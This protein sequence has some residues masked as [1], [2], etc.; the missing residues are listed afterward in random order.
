MFHK[1]TRFILGILAAF[2]GGTMLIHWLDPIT[3][4]QYGLTWGA[5]LIFDVF[6]IMMVQDIYDYLTGVKP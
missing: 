5:T 6:I 3:S 1:I 4:I 2:I